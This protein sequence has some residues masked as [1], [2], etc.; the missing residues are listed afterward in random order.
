MNMPV[1]LAIL[2]AEGRMGQTL[3]NELTHV[4]ELLL[5]AALTKPTSPALGQVLPNAPDIVLSCDMEA[6]LEHCDVLIDFSTPEVSLQAAEIMSKGRPCHTL[7]TGTTGFDP[8]QSAQLQTASHSISLLQSGNFSLGI[9]LLA[10]LVRQA[11]QTL[12]AGW[13]IEILDMHH[14]HKQDA[15]SGTALMLGT[16]AAMG[17]N[18]SGISPTSDSIRTRPRQDGEIGFAIMRGGG[19]T[20]QHEVRIA[21]DQEMISLSHQAFNRSVF[22][23]GAFKAAFWAVKQPAGLY[24]MAH[25][26]GLEQV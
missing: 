11:A 4:P 13:D 8:Q 17:R 10:G 6:A 26:L 25:M 18:P 3:L 24:T 12:Q 5:T 16:A 9:H 2:G 20:G 1:K 22:A 7:V 19:I 21:S 14:K 15:P 23:Y